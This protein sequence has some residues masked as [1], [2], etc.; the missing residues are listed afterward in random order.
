MALAENLHNQNTGQNNTGQ[1]AAG[2][3]NTGPSDWLSRSDSAMGVVTFSLV[4][5]PFGG[6]IDAIN[7]YRDELNAVE[8]LHIA[9]R[10]QAGHSDR[11]TESIIT[12]SGGVSKGEAKKRTKRADAVAK[13]PKLATSL[14]EGT[15]STEHVDLVADAA[16]KTGGDAATDTKLIADIGS[17]NPDQGRAIARKYVEEHQSQGDRD[18]RH[19]WQRARRRVS[20]GRSKNGLSFI[21]LEGDDISIE[22]ALRKLGARADEMYRSDGGRDLAPGEHPRTKV[23]RM[24]DAAIEQLTGSVDAAPSP[25]DTGTGE[26]TTAASK[27]ATPTT[28]PSPP[29]N[30]PGQRPA[31]VFSAKLSDISKDP[32]QLA[33]WT[34]ELVGH[35]TVPSAVAS[36]FR[37]ISDHSAVLLS[38]T[39]QPLWKGRAARLVTAEQWI[40]LVVRDEGCV[41]CTADHTRCE[42]HH[43]LPW[44]APDRGETNIDNL[45]LLCVDCHHRVHQNL[46]T[47]FWDGTEH[48]WRLRAARPGE[49]PPSGQ[50]RSKQGGQH[51]SKYGGQRG[52]PNDRSGPSPGRTSKPSRTPARLQHNE[53]G[54]AN[55]P[56]TEGISATPDDTTTDHKA[57]DPK[58]TDPHARETANGLL[59]HDLFDWIG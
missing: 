56:I 51:R 16:A 35:G 43:L 1:N 52:S 58:T 6:A 11:S 9:Q 41:L 18:S 47:L 55:R 29:R 7:R 59:R 50:H 44:E 45:A 40:A 17:A 20:R 49:I 2:Q 54:E 38:E 31:M 24:F 15:L 25:S 32:E 23:Q 28:P 12:N 36:Y 37:C 3:S 39:G 57:T 10:K 48:R 22:A 19:A 34:A 4:D 46:Q 13:N 21:L 26:G 8:A 33:S 14:T 5:A 53:A 42:A 27:R 30:R